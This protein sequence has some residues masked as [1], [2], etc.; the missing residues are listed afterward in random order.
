[1]TNQ[2][3]YE[4]IW[5]KAKK[6]DRLVEALNKIK[7]EIDLLSDKECYGTTITLYSWEG[8]KRKVFG[9]IDKY[10]KESEE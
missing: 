2:E 1:M 10:Q 7:A 4:L 6:Y 9:I 8:M 5:E 3:Q